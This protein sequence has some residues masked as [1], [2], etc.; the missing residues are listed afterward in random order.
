MTVK[1]EIFGY[2]KYKRRGLSRVTSESIDWIIEDQAFLR[3]YDS[4][5]R[6]P[7]PTSPGSNC[8]Y[9]SVFLCV[10]VRANWREEGDK[11]NHTTARKPGPLQLIQD[12]P[13]YILD[14]VSASLIPAGMA[15]ETVAVLCFV[16][17]NY[18]LVELQQDFKK[19]FSW[20]CVPYTML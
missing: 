9:F 1:N 12:S 19:S 2:L 10:D 13:I 6:L 14:V 18:E 20:K 8:L 7:N 17:Q 4:A 16:N 5:P 3:S 15:K 11:P